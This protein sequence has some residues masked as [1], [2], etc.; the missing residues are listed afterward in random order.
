MMGLIAGACGPNAE[1][2]LS[3]LKKAIGRPSDSYV[4]NKVI[5]LGTR[6]FKSEGPVVGYNND[7][8][9]VVD[10]SGR[11]YNFDWLKQQLSKKNEITSDAELAAYLYLKYD[12]KFIGML[13]GPFSL[14]VCDSKRESLLLSRVKIGESPLYYVPVD[15]QLVFSSRLEVLLNADVIKPQVNTEAVYHYLTLRFVPPPL[16]LYQGMK[17]LKFGTV[18]ICEKGSVREKKYWEMLDIQINY[19]ESEEKTVKKI[20]EMLP[21]IIEKRIDREARIGIPLSGGIDSA[22]LVA[23][24]SQL[25]DRP[26][27]T[28]ATSMEGSVY[29][30]FSDA[31]QVAEKFGTQH[32]ESVISH[33]DV[34]AYLSDMVESSPEPISHAVAVFMH[35]HFSDMRKRKI[36]LWLNGLGPDELFCGYP[37][38]RWLFVAH[39][40]AGSLKVFP[41]SLVNFA[42]NLV[43]G[44]RRSIISELLPDL[45]R[46][47]HGIPF[48]SVVFC[49][50]E[51]RK[52]FDLQF[53]SSF[54]F[55]D[56]PNVF[57]MGFNDFYH[58]VSLVEF[59]GRL[60][61]KLFR[62]GEYVALPGIEVR[63]PYLDM[64][65][66]T[67]ALC[68]PPRMNAKGP[69]GKY[70][71]KKSMLDL[72]PPTTLYKKKIG[73]GSHI[74]RDERFLKSL[75]ETIDDKLWKT[76]LGKYFNRKYVRRL[77]SNPVLNLEK[78]W[79]LLGLTL[80][81]EAWIEK[82]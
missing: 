20:R 8:S 43:G 16:T 27:Y 66:I 40:L 35:H 26:I 55:F 1:Q 2:Y 5:L 45:L 67:Y 29:N 33:E 19:N 10:F 13:N 53:R 41:K 76:D 9:I 12:T 70:L 71:F 11:I 78:L 77:M 73:F 68:I 37:I 22:A 24:A 17:K 79:V 46:S 50:W 44:V 31:K 42:T 48:W 34:R 74:T 28:F 56:T 30:E 21:R 60:P 62:L 32:Y 39:Q 15:D 49:E 52:M 25:C 59:K 61:E 65:F 82:G 63:Y 58:I 3:K 69:A 14:A 23:F 4:D 47:R 7:K 57:G 75:F 72:L 51:K 54:S 64:E 81:H 38:Y 36:N 80:W 18:L 6:D